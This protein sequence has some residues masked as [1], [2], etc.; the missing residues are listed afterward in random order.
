MKIVQS[1]KLNEASLTPEEKMDAWFNGTRKENI[2]AC[3]DSK[4]Q[5]YLEICKDKGYLEQAKQ[6]SDELKNRGISSNEELIIYNCSN[7]PIFKTTDVKEA[8]DFFL[9]HLT[10]MYCSNKEYEKNW[11]YYGTRGKAKDYLD[12]KIENDSLLL[13]IWLCTAKIFKEVEK[14]FNLKHNT[15][16]D[17]LE[18]TIVGGYYYYI[19]PKTNPYINDISQEVLN[20]IKKES[21][22][23]NI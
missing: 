16:V 23:Y 22:D 8:K 3:G 9:N 11:K 13:G 4:L 18:K 17:G 15:I 2:K 6:I 12:F 20:I 5:K 19:V 10:A 1:T 21:K 7:K 14:K